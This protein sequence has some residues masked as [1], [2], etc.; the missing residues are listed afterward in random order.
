MVTNILVLA[1]NPQGTQQLRLNPEIRE[2]EDALDQGQKGDRFDLRSRVAVRV[3][4]LQKSISK[5]KARVVHFCGHGAGSPGLVLETDSGQQQLLNT[6]AIADLF[7]LFKN[8]VECVVLNACYSEEQAKEI[9]KYINYVIGT[10]RAIR[11]DAAIAFSKGFY[12]ALGNGE[13]ISKAFEFGKNRIQLEIYHNDSDRSRKLV[14]IFFGEKNQWVE[15]PEH[16]VVQLLTKEEPL[17]SIIKFDG[18]SSLDRQEIV[19]RSFKA[20]SPYKGLKKFTTDDQ[21]LFFGRD[22][23]IYKLT[24]AIN[25]SN[26]LLVLGAS[27]SG[28]SSVVRAGVIPEL[29]NLAEVS[30]EICIFTPDRDPFESLKNCLGNNEHISN[31]ELDFLNEPQKDAVSKTVNLLKEKHSQWLIFIDQLEELFTICTEEKIRKNFLLGL[32]RIA[33][34][35]DSAI[36]LVLAMRSDFLEEFSPYPKFAKIAQKHIHLVTDMEPNELRQAITK[37]AAKRGVVF[38]QSDPDLVN[39]IIEDV[40]GQAG[41]LPLLQYTLD[42]L[43]QND[44]LSDRELNMVTYHEIGGVKGALQK[45]VN[46]IYNQLSPEKQ[47]ATKQILLRLVD[48]VNEDKSQVLKTAVS[49]RAFKK[50]FNDKQ[51]E[52]IKLLVDENLLISNDS[53]L[54]Q[55]GVSTIE[56]AHEALLSSWGELQ[57]WIVDAKDTIALHNQLTADIKRY[58]ESQQ[59]NPQKAKEELWGGS[60][61][62]KAIELKENGTFERVVGGLSADAQQFLEESVAWRDKEQREKTRLQQRAI[63]F[64]AG[65]LGLAVIAAGAAFGLWRDAVKQ[66]KMAQVQELAVRSEFIRE[67]KANLHETGVLLALESYKRSYNIIESKSNRPSSEA[68]TALNTSLYSLPNHHLS[69][70]SHEDVVSEIEF[71]EDN[72]YFATASDDGTAKLVELATGKETV[73]SHEGRVIGIEF[74]EDNQYF[75]TASSDGTAKLVELATGKETVISHEDQVWEIEFSGDSQYFA[76]ASDDGTAKLVELATGKE[77]VISHEDKVLEIEFSEDNQYFATRSWDGTAKLVELATG[78]ETVISHEDEVTGIE[79]SGDSQYFATRSWDGTAKLVELATGKETV[80]SHE[81]LVW[82]I[83]FSGDNQYFA[84]ASWDGTAKLVELATGKETIISHE[85]QIIG[86]EFSG[87]N[88]YFATASSDGTAKLVELATGKETVISHEDQ[89]WEIEFSGDNQ[90]FATASDDG[91][92]KLVELATGKETVIS[93]EDKVLEIEFSGDNRY[94]ATVSENKVIFVYL[95]AEELIELACDKLS[96]NLSLVYWQRYIGN[97]PYQKTCKKELPIH[98]SFL[99][100]GKRLAQAG[101]INEAVAIFKRARQIKTEIDENYYES[102]NILTQNPKKLANRL[103]APTKLEEGTRLANEGKISEAISVFKQTQ[104][105]DPKL[106]INATAWNILCRN[107]SLNNQAKEVM[108]ACNNAVEIASEDSDIDKTTKANYYD[109]RGL[110]LALTGKYNEAIADFEFFVENSE[111]SEEVISKR[112]NWIKALKNGK[113]PFEDDEVLEGLKNE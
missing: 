101:K 99:R 55:E 45:H 13:T 37:P 61:L 108:F 91:T 1:S 106:K 35:N 9:R 7:A 94:F 51:L 5:S 113:N 4:D 85:D 86:I 8:Q 69:A 11:D 71:S 68:H 42:L 73:I 3:D 29:N 82:E 110:A 84:T 87:D 10:K 14:P 109:S 77:T 64:L 54:T 83:E 70:I 2:I 20:Q 63:K 105:L 18:D 72:Q 16:E 41:S 57:Q 27:G 65:G 58:R 90:Y 33:R 96:E 76:T 6:N 60:K 23:L 26:L 62:E 104:I 15:L 34:A 52:T 88:Q 21:D 95:D 100:E 19:N 81:D 28:K 67:Q 59:R 103:Y 38:E 39:K 80:I 75:A 92:A 48:V 74:S 31:A 47:Q 98:P 22:R 12:E 89:V 49:K 79:F 93:H 66:T 36:K 25:R 53:D 44:D 50:E 30:Y 102:E 107:G 40:Q 56:I 43:W 46:Q 24:E 78:K 97:E 32:N 17:N 112:E 111:I